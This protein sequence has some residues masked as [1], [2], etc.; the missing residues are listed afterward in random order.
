MK[1]PEPGSCAQT[2]SSMIES[3]L[4]IPDR[5]K[6][7]QGEVVTAKSPVGSVTAS[8]AFLWHR[9]SGCGSVGHRACEVCRGCLPPTG[10]GS[11]SRARLRG[12]E[13]V[14]ADRRFCSDACRQRAYRRR[15]AT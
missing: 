7:A 12:S 8:G 1:R 2:S 14:R 13:S 4:G 9:C 11:R 15:R 5:E 6:A 3:G 10:L